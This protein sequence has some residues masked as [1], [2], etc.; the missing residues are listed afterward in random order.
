MARVWIVNPFDPLPGAPE[1]PGRYT[2][3]AR[4]LRAAGHDLTWWT[5]TF[6][7]RFKDHLERAPIDEASRREGIDVRW[8]DAPPYRHNVGLRRLWS[9][10]TW[11]LRMEAEAAR[12]TSVSPPHVVIASNPP[13]EGAAATA[14]LARRCGA[15]LV[16]DVQDIWVGNFRQ[17]LP[18]VVRWAWPALLRPWIRANQE[19]FA[20]ADAVVGVAGAYVDEA[21]RYG[22]RDVRRA[23]VP[24]GIDLSGFDRA[25]ASG[26]C[27]L[28]AKRPGEIW[29]IYSGSYSR[30][31]DVRTVANVAATIVSRVDHVRFI[32]SGTGA[33]ESEIR[34]RLAGL[35]RIDFLGFAPFED[36]AA[37]L[38]QCDIGWNAIKPE[39]LIWFPN[40]IF[41]YWAAGLAVAN[42]IPGECAEW[43]TRTGTGVNYQNDNVESAVAAFLTLSKDPAHLENAKCASR[44][45]AV[46]RWDRARLYRSYLDLVSELAD[47][48]H[49]GNW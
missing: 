23:V 36:W 46:E 10:R 7:H 30:S 41:Y 17:L 21:R 4:L 49:A 14:R 40:K 26:R 6:S 43:V 34:E 33:L 13:P 12:R 15:A 38:R 35:P 11:A 27:L 32:F 29:S 1:Q 28:G 16:V 48:R 18:G 24:I 2:S 9:H 42:S 3:L 37:T 31:Y 39:A 47:G 44:R 8:I 19:S 20:V 5:A 25:A 45:A 22:R